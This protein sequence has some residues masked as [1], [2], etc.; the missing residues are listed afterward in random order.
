MNK[1]KPLNTTDIP[2]EFNYRDAH[3]EGNL[4]IPENAKGFVIFVHNLN[5]N[6]VSKGNWL[7]AQRLQ[8][9]GMAT[10]IVD[11]M[12]LQEQ[13]ALF[14]RHSLNEEVD[15]ISERLVFILNKFSENPLVRS[16]PVIL[17]G[18]DLG[19]VAAIRAAHQSAVQTDAIIVRGG[20]LD[21]VR[22]IL[23]DIRVPVL[24]LIGGDDV[25]TNN[26]TRQALP[27]APE[28]FT[29][30]RI[31]NG[32]HLF[33]EVGAMEAV[34]EHSAAWLAEQNFAPTNQ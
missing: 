2:V 11:F 21:L 10:L 4:D 28:L 27:N 26:I 18:S 19:A 25:L 24:V 5:E 32:G 9:E 16:L 23:P 12:S 3:L 20:P 6:H 15:L 31:E 17:F 7:V 1:I 14:S 34:A 22:D 8:L 33:E 30:E 13:Q 29:V